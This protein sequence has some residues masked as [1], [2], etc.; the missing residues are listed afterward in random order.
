MGS[1]GWG[2]IQ[3]QVPKY[4]LVYTYSRMGCDNPVFLL[5]ELWAWDSVM[6]MENAQME[7]RHFF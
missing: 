3:I 6:V 7:C 4:S 5:G 2:K 1:S